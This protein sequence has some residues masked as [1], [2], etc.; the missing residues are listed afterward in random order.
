MLHQYKNEKFSL[1]TVKAQRIL[2]QYDTQITME[3]AEIMLDLLRK[4]S[5]LSVSETVKHVITCQK[6]APEGEIFKP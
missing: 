1:I 5:K 4:L 6:E 3:D 2:A